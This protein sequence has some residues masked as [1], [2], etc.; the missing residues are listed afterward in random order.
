MFSNIHEKIKK[1]AII[2]FWVFTVLSVLDGFYFAARREG[3]NFVLA[4][5]FMFVVPVFN[6]VASLIMY[7]FG[8]LIENTKDTK[9]VL[10]EINT[11][12]TTTPEE[13]EEKAISDALKF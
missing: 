3:S 12:D 7:G 9:N 6:Y 4:I 13:R 10:R 8:E 5:F 2:Y 11:F 1:A